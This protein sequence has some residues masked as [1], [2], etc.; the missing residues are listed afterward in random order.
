MKT[1]IDTSSLPS[2]LL[3][4][5]STDKEILIPIYPD[6]S[7]FLLKSG[8]QIIYKVTTAREYLY[9]YVTCKSLGLSL[10]MVIEGR[11]YS[12]SYPE[13]SDRF[14]LSDYSIMI[15]LDDD[16][17]VTNSHNISGV[18]I[19]N[20]IEYPLSFIYAE[21]EKEGRSYYVDVSNIVLPEDNLTSIT[22][23]NKEDEETPAVIEIST[24][25]GFFSTPCESLVLELS[26]V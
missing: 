7:L 1:L 10:E 13:D 8:E 5:N 25:D 21:D 16:I 9:Y 23:Y 22:I 18:F 14:T 3:I 2:N 6:N 15:A 20:G 26:V 19:F 4:K 11:S 12:F 24:K 17:W